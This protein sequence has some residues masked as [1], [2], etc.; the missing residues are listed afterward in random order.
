MWKAVPAIETRGR[1]EPLTGEILMD[2]IDTHDDLLPPEPNLFERLLLWIN[3]ADDQ[4]AL[5]QCPRDRGS[6]L[7][8][9][10]IQLLSFSY[11]TGL[12]TLG[13]H[14]LFAPPGQV[15]FELL[16]AS[17]FLGFFVLVIDSWM[18][19][20][21]GHFHTGAAQ[22][23]KAGL[24]ISGGPIARLK[25]GIAWTIRF[26][27]SIALA[28]LTALVLSL[29]VF[30]PDINAR[31]QHDTLQTNTHLLGPATALVDGA[32]QRETAAVVDQTKLVNTLAQQVA[33][34]RQSSVDPA[35]G[36]P[37]IQE[38]QQEVA[39]LAAEKAKADEEVQ[40]AQTFADN[41]F[42]GIKGAVGNS[43]VPGYGLRWKAAREHVAQAK[44]HAEDVAKQLDA[45]R[46]RLD[47]LRAQKSSTNATLMQQAHG[48]LPIF[49]KRLEEENERLKSLKEQLASSIANRDDD[50][51]KAIQ[52]APDFVGFQTGL[53]ARVIALEAIAQQDKRLQLVIL[54]IEVVSLSLES[55]ALLAKIVCPIPTG[56]AT[57]VTRDA[58]MHDIRVVNEMMAELNKRDDEEDQ[59]DPLP[60]IDPAPDSGGAAMPIEAANEPVPPSKSPK[61][62]RGRPRIHPVETHPPRKP[63]PRKHPPLTVITGGI[64][65]GP[66]GQPP[67]QPAPV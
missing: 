24:D 55:A 48:R 67:E 58:Y 17:I 63:N 41:E 35:A 33:A 20:R 22:L 25:I 4:E 53:I 57:L 42:G 32:I 54:L 34:L 12:I 13:A 45:A 11:L 9:G 47:S 18:I 37:E 31:I 14:M 19:L 28:Q 15:R 56:Y 6:L 1:A 65:Q 60:P 36:D 64:G 7:A 51:R 43:G 29:M 49:E 2:A 16:A 8:P 30:A 61:R 40:A 26:I 50:I 46:E 3:G 62:G 39:R 52:N 10:L 21:A 27:L 66:E 23:R 44:A 5:R 38:A 59:S